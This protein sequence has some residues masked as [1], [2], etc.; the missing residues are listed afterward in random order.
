MVAALAWP[1]A[2]VSLAFGFRQFIAELA[3]GEIKRWKAGP[4][5]VEIEYWDR[6]ATEIKAAVREQIPPSSGAEPDLAELVLP[7]DL[8]GAV[9]G[10]Y[11]T[12]ER[13]LRRL[14]IDNGVVVEGGVDRMSGRRLANAALDADLITPESATAIEGLSVLRNLTAHGQAQQLD[15][16]RAAEFVA[17]TEAVLFALRAKE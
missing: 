4:S 11:A 12:I 1:V 15:A 9:V 3:R 13:E 10:S 2:V 14:L 7:G 8:T 17:M 6:E 5:G 16:Q